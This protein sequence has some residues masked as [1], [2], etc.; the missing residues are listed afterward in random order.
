MQRIKSIKNTEGKTIYNTIFFDSYMLQVYIDRSFSIFTYA[1]ASYEAEGVELLN[2]EDTFVK[3]LNSKEF[4]KWL[5]DKID[6]ELYL[7]LTKKD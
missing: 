7:F 6:K 4:N 5:K 3:P 2:L 1:G